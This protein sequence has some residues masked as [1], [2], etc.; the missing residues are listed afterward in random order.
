[1]GSKK[2][3]ISVIVAS[4][5]HYAILIAALLKSIDVNHES[6]EHIDFYIIDDGI[7]KENKTKIAETVDPGRITLMWLKSKGIVPAGVTIPVDSS[8]YPM[9]VYLRLFGP[10]AVGEEVE[11]LIYLDVDTIVQQDISALWNTDLGDFTIGAVQ[12]V[13]KTVACEWGGIPNYLELGLTA[14]TKYFN[15]GVLLI[16]AKKWRETNR[17]KKVIQTLSEYR[18]YVRLPDQY[19]LNVVFAEKW[20]EL[21]PRWNWF[22]F[23][24]REEPYIIHFLDIKPIFKTYNSQPAFKDEFFRYLAMTPWKNF[25][26][27]SGNQRYKR[28]VVNKVKN[29]FLKIAKSGL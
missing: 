8:A 11:K 6:Q 23:A 9:T 22:A 3:H 4:D 7:S 12:D 5:N 18:K 21:D 29:M 25:K 20:L 15:S 28:K 2:D 16:N 17:S 13:G 24:A 10:H 19:G 26:P 1:M 14:D 27:L